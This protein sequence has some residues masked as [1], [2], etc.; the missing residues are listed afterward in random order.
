MDDI[1]VC[2]KK[3]LVSGGGSQKV[4][5]NWNVNNNDNNG[6]KNVN[7]NCN[8]SFK[9]GLKV[10]NINVRGIVSSVN[11]R[12]ELNHWIEL[13]DLDVVCIQEWYILHD[14]QIEKKEND[15]ND[16]NGFD[17]YDTFE[18]ENKNDRRYLSVTLDMA[19]FQKY[20]KIETNTK[21]LILY[22]SNLK[23]VRFDL[24]NEI[25]IDGL[26]TTW[27]GIETNKCIFIIGSVYHSPSYNCE[28]DE[29][30]LQWNQLKHVCRHYNR[31]TTIIAG[32]FNSKNELW[33]STITDNRGIN[34]AD[35][36]VTNGFQ[37]N[38]DG[39]HTYET[40]KKRDVLDISMI[41]Q[42]EVNLVKEWYVQSIPSKN[43]RFSDHRGIVM[44]INSDPKIKIIPTRITW[45][46]DEKKVQK[47]IDA[48][49]P[50]IMEWEHTYNCLYKDKQN[51]E[52]LVEY[53]QLIIVE[54]AT[55]IF[56]FKK[57]CQDSVNW[58][59][60]KVHKILKKK[61]KISNKISHMDS[62]FRKRYGSI[63]NTPY[64]QKKMMKKQKKKLRK[65]QKKLKKNKYKNIL[66]STANIER[67]INNSN[68]NQEK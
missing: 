67:L 18:N 51:V 63:A 58:V 14:R 46:L 16:D 24:L 4:V 5:N 23:V 22:K 34:L 28:Y 52:L 66:Q 50:K 45:N 25:S 17:N 62:K 27:I 53:F 15:S 54:T 57:Y 42:N 40:D 65:L 8:I 29:I 31:I 2:T 19:A 30:V 49:K 3:K 21:T 20:D 11:K 33:G 55:E 1:A 61:K 41:T 68:V 35:W 26:D 12:I 6:N 59:D 37:F 44:V 56:G 43:D 13:N 47:F 32:D 39:T 38:N 36:M 64:N 9:R 60:K 48:L 10:G 7:V